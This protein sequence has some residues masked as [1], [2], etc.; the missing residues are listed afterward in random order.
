ME[1]LTEEEKIT[2]SDLRYEKAEEMLTD[3]S[4]TLEMGLYKTSVNRSYYAALH[5][6]RALLVLKGADP[7]T[8]DGTIRIFSLDFV[9]NDIVPK[10]FIKILK[11]LLSM[12]T[13]VDYGDMTTVDESDA[14]GA[15][16]DA[17]LFVREVN[18]V[19]KKLIS[20]LRQ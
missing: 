5:A 17:E 20:E 10:K 4:K 3:A 16:K 8:H 14:E 15:L 13:D 7:V 19:R 18:R 1:K 9:K 12:R 2:L 6:A 11:S